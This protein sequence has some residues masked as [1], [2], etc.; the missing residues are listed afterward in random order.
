[1]LH[2]PNFIGIALSL[3]L[4]FASTVGAL[5]F[6]DK[7]NRSFEGEILSIKG[8]FVKLRR[9]ADRQIF[10]V[11][12]SLFSEETQIQ[13]KKWQAENSSDDERW[14][15]KLRAGESIR[16]LPRQLRVDLIWE[17]GDLPDYEVARAKQ[18]GGP[19][20]T[21]PNPTPGFHLYSDYLGAAGLRYFYRVRNVRL[22]RS[23]KIIDSN[24][25]SEV[26]H[27]E[28]RAFDLNEFVTEVQE[29]AV[30]FYFEAGHPV[31]GLSPE[32]APGWGDTS[33]VGSSGMG[34]ANLIVGVHRGFV[35]REQGIEQALKMLRFLDRN[36]EKQ[37]G[38]FAHWMDGATGAPRPFGRN[39]KAADLVETSFLIQGAI[40]LR[41]YFNG[42]SKEEREIGEIVTRL[43][44]G[45]EWPKFVATPE[46]APVIMWHWDAETGQ[47]DLPIRGFHEAMMPYILAIG[48]ATHPIPAR[49]FYTG[50][51]HP[52]NGLGQRRRHFKIEHS[53][54]YG[55]GWP[56]FFAHYSHIGFDPREIRYDGQ[57][58]FE[59]FEAAT[60]IHKAYAH[61]RAKEFKGYDKVWGLTASLSPFGYKAHRPGPADNGTIAT[62]AALS[63]MP[64]LPDEV[65]ECMKAMYLD[66]GDRIWGCFGFY[67]AFN[68]TEDWIGEKYIGIELGPIAPM[69]ENHRSGL[70]WKLFM[71]A[72]EV[73]RA[74]A[75]LDACSE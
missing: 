74:Q 15:Y 22:D 17:P 18:A 31:S 34:M 66:Y 39:G 30:R 73:K 11:A 60:K 37:A 71:Q 48:S 51:Y 28:T 13:L 32:G 65:L 45:I 43:A 23:G 44:D 68:P 75:R 38:A 52:T 53:L 46:T 69:I 9:F 4:A 29:A 56:L 40:L 72:P 55:V 50:F 33:A 54:G 24:D 27:A 7:Q 14:L 64:Y 12:S 10:E 21:L 1:M 62:T 59:H 42:S 36:T 20:E 35:T 58:Y 41:E 25:W 16:A 3:F 19:W 2:F 57:T 6:S 63:S 70:F 49:S 5:T 67:N 47:S 26:V 61:S 8:E